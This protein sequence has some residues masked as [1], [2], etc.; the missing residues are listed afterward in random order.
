M[1]KRSISDWKTITTAVT[2]QPL[3]RF[4][5]KGSTTFER[6]QVVHGRGWVW[7]DYGR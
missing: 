4:R 3:G 6:L 2:S 5:A 1:P 7:E